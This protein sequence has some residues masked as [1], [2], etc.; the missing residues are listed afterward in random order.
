MCHNFAPLDCLSCPSPC[1]AQLQYLPHCVSSRP[2]AA[3]PSPLL[4]LRSSRPSSSSRDP[5]QVQRRSPLIRQTPARPCLL[6]LAIYHWRSAAHPHLICRSRHQAVPCLQPFRMR[7]STQ[8]ISLSLL[9]FQIHRT[10]KQL[11]SAYIARSLPIPDPCT[12]F[13]APQDR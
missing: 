7:S 1:S 8:I 9:L 2:F 10:H 11:I 5:A 6:Y 3:H 12:A 4:V 13:C